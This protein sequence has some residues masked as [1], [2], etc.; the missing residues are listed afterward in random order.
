MGCTNKDIVEEACKELEQ[1]DLNHHQ[2]GAADGNGKAIISSSHPVQDGE[3]EEGQLDG[4][5]SSEG[6]QGYLFYNLSFVCTVVLFCLLFLFRSTI[7]F[8]CISSV[9]SVSKV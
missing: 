3:E 2:V 7:V 6:L 4:P 5:S 8:A 1:M 9:L